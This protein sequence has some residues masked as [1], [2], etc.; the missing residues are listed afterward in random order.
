MKASHVVGVGAL[1]VCALIFRGDSVE[2]QDGGGTTQWEEMPMASSG[3][4]PRLE[5]RMSRMGS[6]KDPT[7]HR[8]G[9]V[10]SLYVGVPLMN[11]VNREVVRPGGSIDFRGGIDLGYFVP[12][13]EMGFMGMPFKARKIDS[14]YDNGTLKQFY[15]G[16]GGRLQIPNNTP[17][18]PYVAGAFDFQFWNL[19][20][21]YVGCS[22]WYCYEQNEY[23]FTPGFTGRAG[24]AIRFNAHIALDLNLR[25]GMSFR[26][27]VFDESRSWLQP[28][29]GV[30]FWR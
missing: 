18:L 4:D 3:S 30:S 15:F 26:G 28:S 2:A 23:S 9:P 5:K 25:V 17:V 6:P 19:Y 24:L 11:K 14:S 16:F 13:F 21:T 10:G 12:E 8:R 29:L 27:A 20:D 1:A 7:Q 22:Y